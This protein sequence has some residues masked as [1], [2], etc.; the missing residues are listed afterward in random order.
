MDDKNIVVIITLIVLV[1]LS[2]LVS[3]ISDYA[4]KKKHERKK[5]LAKSG[6]RVPVNDR[7]KERVPVNTFDKNIPLLAL[8]IQTQANYLIAKEVSYLRT[9]KKSSKFDRKKAGDYVLE[10]IALI[11]AFV[12]H[13]NY[14]I[15]DEW[16]YLWLK[17]VS[18]NYVTSSSINQ[19]NIKEL[20]ME[21]IDFYKIE[22][23]VIQTSHFALPNSIISQIYKPMMTG[24]LTHE[25]PFDNGF[26]TMENLYIWRIIGDEVNKLIDKIS[27]HK[28]LMYLSKADYDRLSSNINRP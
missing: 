15:K 6:N 1:A 25:M 27:K 28:D 13:I 11:C 17:S 10:R 24:E 8:W 23:E 3:K 21:R 26:N 18:A 20:I 14:A 19:T 12:K 7:A 16:A 9:I 4:D 22:I 2:F 5:E